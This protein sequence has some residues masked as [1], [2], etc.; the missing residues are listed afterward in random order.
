MGARNHERLPSALLI[1][2][3]QEH[4]VTGLLLCDFLHDSSIAASPSACLFLLSCHDEIEVE[5]SPYSP[6]F[7]Q[8]QNQHPRSVF[9]LDFLSIHLSHV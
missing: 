5:L 4:R 7:V 3:R 1:E 8:H 2:T 9:H 6:T